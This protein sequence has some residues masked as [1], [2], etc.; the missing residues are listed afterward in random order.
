MVADRLRAAGLTVIEAANG[1]EAAEVLRSGQAE[2]GLVFSD[3][4]MSGSMDGV[5]LAK[6]I[7]ANHPQIKI[8]LTSGHLTE[9][10]RADHDSFFRKPYQLEDVVAHIRSLLDVEHKSGR[11][12]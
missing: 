10:D 9:P 8:V 1:R 3:V 12:D 7:R 11:N 5:G 2:V 6:F 4:R